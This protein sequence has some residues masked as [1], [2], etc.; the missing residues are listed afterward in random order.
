MVNVWIL[1]LTVFL[2]N[3][4]DSTIGMYTYKLHKQKLLI[5]LSI[6]LRPVRYCPIEQL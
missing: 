3:Q 5:F 1:L 4:W 6:Y 2:F